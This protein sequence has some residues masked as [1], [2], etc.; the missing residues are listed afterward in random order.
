MCKNIEN[1]FYALLLKKL[2]KV[3][4]LTNYIYRSYE[5]IKFLNNQ[6]IIFFEQAKMR[7]ILTK[8]SIQYKVYQTERTKFT[9]Y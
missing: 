9:N 5:G 8:S 3:K 4:Q 7:L 1:S 2:N 6:T